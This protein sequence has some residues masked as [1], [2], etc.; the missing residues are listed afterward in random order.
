MKHDKKH[1][2]HIFSMNSYKTNNETTTFPRNP[3]K[4]FARKCRGAKLLEPP[5]Q[6][7]GEAAGHGQ[8]QLLG[9]GGRVDQQGNVINQHTGTPTNW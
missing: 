4:N 9:V 3:G 6:P 1:Q 8:E 7:L 2:K 5:G